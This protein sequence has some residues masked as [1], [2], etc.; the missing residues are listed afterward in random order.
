MSGGVRCG[1]GLR[2]GIAHFASSWKAFGWGGGGK[3]L[4]IH[5][6]IWGWGVVVFVPWLDR[7]C[8][9]MESLLR[10]GREAWGLFGALWMGWVVQCGAACQRILIGCRFGQFAFAT[11]VRSDL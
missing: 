9:L 2:G 4:V 3:F 5:V 1:V 11:S 6:C 7:H 8:C 10:R